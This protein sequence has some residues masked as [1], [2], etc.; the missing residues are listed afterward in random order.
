MT[1]REGWSVGLRGI[2]G[3]RNGDREG[4]KD[5]GTNRYMVDCDDNL[6]KRSP[7]RTHQCVHALAVGQTSDISTHKAGFTLRTP[8]A[9]N[10]IAQ[11]NL[12][13]SRGA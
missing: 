9:R 11:T 7:K 12:R 13:M 5:G 4:T 6:I 3:V 8:Y 2:T 10:R 1:G